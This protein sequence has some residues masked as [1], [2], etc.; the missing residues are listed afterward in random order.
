MG[1]AAYP[2]RPCGISLPPLRRIPARPQTG[3]AV[4]TQY[5]IEFCLFGL[6]D[7]FPCALGRIASQRKLSQQKLSV[8]QKPISSRREGTYWL[9]FRVLALCV[10]LYYKSRPLF[11][12][13]YPGLF[14]IEARLSFIFSARDGPRLRM[15]RVETFCYTALPCMFINDRLC[16]V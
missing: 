12:C 1:I 8:V 2:C 4:I 16:P 14:S 3:V 15:I 6:V 10:A 11:L 9:H 13:W 7:Q 5:Q